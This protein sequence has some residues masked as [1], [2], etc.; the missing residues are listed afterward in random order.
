MATGN[1]LNCETGPKFEENDPLLSE[2]W[3]Q[4]CTVMVATVSLATGLHCDG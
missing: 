3:L 4:A 1:C 2:G